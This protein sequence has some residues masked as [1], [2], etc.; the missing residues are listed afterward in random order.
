MNKA[1]SREG[2]ATAQPLLM[3]RNSVKVR[4]EVGCGR[5]L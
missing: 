5:E 4:T 2:K 1:Q 3:M